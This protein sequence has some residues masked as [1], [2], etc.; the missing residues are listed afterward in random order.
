MVADAVCD[1]DLSPTPDDFS[2]SY[3]VLDEAELQYIW[4]LLALTPLLV[5]SEF[6]CCLTIE[7]A[8]LCR[9]SEHLSNITVIL[10][11]PRTLFI[12]ST[13]ITQG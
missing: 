11:L 9:S 7:S 5:P 10:V 6:H 8:E 4:C 12:A 3:S 1:G 13:I 2:L